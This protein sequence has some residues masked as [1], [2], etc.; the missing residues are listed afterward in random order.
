MALHFDGSKLFWHLDRLAA[1]MENKE[2]PPVHVEISPTNACNYRCIFCYADYSGHKRSMIP[3]ST[4]L[5]IMRDMGAMDI[6]SCLFAGDGEPLLHPAVPEAI[7]VGKEAGVDMALNTNAFLL[8]QKTSELV[9]PMLV[10][11]RASVMAYSP[12]I[13]GRLHG[14]SPKNLNVVLR[15]L[16]QAA[17]IKRKHNL[18]VTIGLQQV[19]LPE[20]GHETPKLAAWAR[21]AGLDYYVLKPFSLHGENTYY[22]DGV[23][24]ISLRDQFREFLLEAESMSTESFSSI[25]RW[26]TFSDDGIKEYDRCLGLPFILQ[27]ASDS[28]AYTCC[29]Y[30][31]KEKFSYGDLNSQRLR[32]VW[33]SEKAIKLRKDIA[34]NYDISRC[35]T[36]CR[37]HQINKQLWKLR[38]PP[39]HINFI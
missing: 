27:I 23:S 28:N 12:D 3:E 15:N 32:D 25:I 17:L 36:Y 22:K 9:L 19:L 20:N 26:N 8:D 35:M 21:D 2:I 11:L 10:W 16:E 5:Q 7:R 33:F 39:H 31:G 38:N 4:L 30:F 1:W 18:D 14:T 24:A 29:P 13:Y 6:R 34:L 37:H